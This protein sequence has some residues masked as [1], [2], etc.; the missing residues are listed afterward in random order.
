[1]ACVSGWSDRVERIEHDPGARGVL[2]QSIQFV[3]GI[4]E[5]KRRQEQ[6]HRSAVCRIHR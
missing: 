2:H 3:R 6:T 4:A 5:A 1:M